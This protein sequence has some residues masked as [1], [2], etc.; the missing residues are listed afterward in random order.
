[1]EEHSLECYDVPG[2][3]E[4]PVG[5]SSQCLWIYMLA[6]IEC[7]RLC[8]IYANEKLRPIR[9]EF[10]VVH[11]MGWFSVQGFGVL[12]N[13]GDAFKG[14]VLI[15]APLTTSDGIAKSNLI[16]K[17][18]FKTLLLHPVSYKKKNSAT[19]VVWF[20]SKWLLWTCCF[21]ECF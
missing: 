5:W 14:K 15:S 8:C 2:S 21:N 13:W 19:S 18:L 11:N 1:M 20:T 9:Q 4:P 12:L 16:P 6:N 10:C 7:R 17:Q 3:L